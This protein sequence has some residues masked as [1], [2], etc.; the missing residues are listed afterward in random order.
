MI[1]FIY[2]VVELC[3]VLQKK[4][5][6]KQMTH[7]SPRS[8]DSLDSP[9]P[10][11]LRHVKPSVKK[12]KSN[13]KEHKKD[14]NNSTLQKT[15][16]GVGVKPMPI[17]ESRINSHTMKNILGRMYR[18]KQYLEKLVTKNGEYNE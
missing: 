6:R 10:V 14:K 16:N 7:V 11:S 8:N 12:I 2:Y 9:T 4:D 3:S 17:D 1:D 5:T 15:D 18:D 13:G